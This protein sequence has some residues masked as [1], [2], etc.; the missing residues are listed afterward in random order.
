MCIRIADNF[1]FDVDDRLWWIC[2]GSDGN[3]LGLV[4]ALAFAI[5]FYFD[6]AFA[7]NRDWLFWP[8][9]NGATTAAFCIA[10][11]QRLFSCVFENVLVLYFFAGFY[12]TEVEFRFVEL[13]SSCRA[14]WGSR[15]C[16][17]SFR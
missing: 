5:E 10:D 16:R 7:T 15:L 6:F 8:L 13:N 17:I 1:T 4:T 14:G 11:D 12:L 2:I 9:R 3:L